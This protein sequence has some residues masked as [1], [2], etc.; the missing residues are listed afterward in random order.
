MR[1]GVF[2]RR[3]HQ[4]P[5]LNTAALPDLI[6]TVLFFFMIVTHMRDVD[7]LVRYNVPQGTEL[8][9]LAHKS[10]VVYIYVGRT[11][12]GSDQFAIQ[13][14]NRL[15]TVDDIRAYIEEERSRMAT[16]DQARLTVSIKADR[17]V[18]MSLIAD[19]KEALRQSYALKI[20]YSA[21]NKP[22]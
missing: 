6:F 13:L 1:R 10:S 9:K 5:G 21:T 22:Q 7:P 15:A 14:N 12:K 20:N 2:K 18:P 17:D 4:M 11:A 16:D 19:V 3:E 8:Q